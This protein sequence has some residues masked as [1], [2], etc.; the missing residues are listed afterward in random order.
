MI[1][2]NVSENRGSSWVAAFIGIL[3]NSNKFPFPILFTG[4]RS[5]DVDCACASRWVLA[6]STDVVHSAHP[7]AAIFLRHQGSITLLP[8]EHV[9]FLFLQLVNVY[10]S[11]A[12]ISGYDAVHITEEL[13]LGGQGQGFDQTG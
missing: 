8:V 3:S 12:T 4:Q 1:I 7:P 13:A 6:D 9:H 5:S 10:T 2:G 11:H